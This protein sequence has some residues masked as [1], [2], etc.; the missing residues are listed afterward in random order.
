MNGEWMAAVTIVSSLLVCCA[1]GRHRRAAVL[2]EWD[3][4]LTSSGRRAVA[5]VRDR[6]EMDALMAGEAYQGAVE[7]W[8]GSNVREA[9]RL[10][11]LAASVLS[12]STQDRLVR[13]R[14]MVVCARMAAAIL[15]PA[16]VAPLQFNLRRLSTLTGLGALAHHFLVSPLERFALR[17]YVV[18]WGLQIAVRFLVRAQDNPAEWQVF[19]RAKDD[20]ETLDRAHLE[21]FELLMAS[22][23]A[24]PKVQEQLVVDL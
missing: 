18:G 7:A 24:E 20:W 17:A 6:M 13:L 3:A 1:Y 10:L 16:P 19:G 5:R 8:S 22:L 23:G 9:K 2:R 14:G 15:P 21:S 11:T 12:D 4:L